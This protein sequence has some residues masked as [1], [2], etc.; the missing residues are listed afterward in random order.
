MS[1]IDSLTL[2]SEHNGKLL[3]FASAFKITSRSRVTTRQKVEIQNYVNRRSEV[4]KKEDISDCIAVVMIFAFLRFHFSILSFSVRKVLSAVTRS[5]SSVT[6]ARSS[7]QGRA[8]KEFLPQW[9]PPRLFPL[10]AMCVAESPLGMDV[11]HA[12]RAKMCQ[13]SAI[14]C[15]LSSASSLVLD[16]TVFFSLAGE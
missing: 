8:G 1:G 4:G 5:R 9:L 2:G 11:N 6:F 7:T 3:A 13:G 15:V 10:R 12:R 14:P 16:P